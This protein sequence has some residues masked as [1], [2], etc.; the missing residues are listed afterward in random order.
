MKSEYHFYTN[1]NVFGNTIRCRGRSLSGERVSDRDQFQP[2]MYV[3]SQVPSEYKTIDGHY[4]SPVIA[5]IANTRQMIKQYSEIENYTL[6]G[7]NNFD[8]QYIG[9]KHPDGP[10]PWDSSH[11]KVANIDIEVASENGFPDPEKADQPII[12]I[13]IKEHDR[14]I[15]FATNKYGTYTP[16]R[17]DIT[18]QDYMTKVNCLP[19]F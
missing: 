7:N 4:V 9:T 15:V 13:T 12:A 2:T 3:P 16:H 1:V 10:A 8:I 19:L 17:A 18:Y 11:I 5:P 6:Y 14:Y